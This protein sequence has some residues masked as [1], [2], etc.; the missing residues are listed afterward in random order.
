[1]MRTLIEKVLE[2]N[3]ALPAHGLVVFTWG[4]V[5]AIDRSSGLVAIKGSGIPYDGMTEADIVVLDLDGNTVRA[6]R[7]PSSDVATHL[8]LYRRFPGI[9]GIVHTH[10]RWATSWAQSCRDLPAYGTTHADTFYGSVPCTR[11]LTDQEILGEYELETGRVIAEAFTGR[12]LDP[13]S[14]PAVLVAGHGPF[15]WGTDAMEAVHNAVVLEE[16]AMMALL[17]ER[18]APD[19]V[20]IGQTLLDRHFL[21]KHGK[22]AYYGQG[23]EV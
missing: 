7:R 6:N 8:E 3:L 13:M 11:L 18:I 2:A 19:T 15:C 10:S 1:M 5:S 16:C 4:N 20:P 21:R 9:G 17:T 12:S 23:G 14:V 22:D